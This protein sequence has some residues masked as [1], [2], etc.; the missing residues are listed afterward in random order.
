MAVPN[1]SHTVTA[2]TNQAAGT[3]FARKNFYNVKRFAAN[4]YESGN[5]SSAMHHCIACGTELEM[6]RLAC[7]RCGVRYEGRF[8]LP[9]LAR[10]GADEQTLAERIL[11][12]G[13]N[14]KAVAEELQV[15]YPTLR[16]RVDRLQAALRALQSEDGELIDRFLAAVEAGSLQAEEAARLI[17]ELHGG[18]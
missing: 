8:L 5:L 16:K 18:S 10:L 4:L 13:G 3:C 1:G 7:A 15:S 9:R 12:A 11:L 17:K 6:A 14:L 2:F